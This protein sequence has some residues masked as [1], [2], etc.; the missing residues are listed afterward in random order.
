MLFCFFERYGNNGNYLRCGLVLMM[1]FLVLWDLVL[2]VDDF[3]A[4][5]TTSFLSTTSLLFEVTLI[6]NIYLLLLS[7]VEFD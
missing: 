6:D 3:A 7:C 2:Q 1:G 4:A 5:F